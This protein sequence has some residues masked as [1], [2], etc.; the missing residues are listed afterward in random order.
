MVFANGS[1]KLPKLRNLEPVAPSL[2]TLRTFPPLAPPPPGA[3][4]GA[5]GI[6]PKVKG[7]EEESFMGP[8]LSDPVG[9]VFASR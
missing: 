5:F 7:I 9:L 4:P 2:L 3:T 1:G 6:R 8:A